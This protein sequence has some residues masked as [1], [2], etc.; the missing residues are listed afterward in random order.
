MKRRKHFAFSKWASTTPVPSCKSARGIR[1]HT[2]PGN[3]DT[4][5]F[6]NRQKVFFF[7]LLHLQS[8]HGGQ[9]SYKGHFA[10]DFE[11]WG[12][13]TCLLCSTRFLRRLLMKWFLIKKKRIPLQISNM[14][15]GE[16]LRQR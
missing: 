5:I 7:L 14:K 11:K 16:T 2:L 4:W 8:V 3:F 12:G 10:R 13:G 6:R 1:R 15:V 9:P